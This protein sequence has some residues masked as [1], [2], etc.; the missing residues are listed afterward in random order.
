VFIWKDFKNS[1][2]GTNRLLAAMFVF[3][4]IGLGILILSKI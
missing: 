3:Y 1:P 2:P 4:I